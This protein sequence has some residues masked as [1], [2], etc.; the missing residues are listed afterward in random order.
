MKKQ[1][2]NAAS[3]AQEAVNRAIA[4]SD[5]AGWAIIR[6]R[7]LPY[8]TTAKI[9]QKAP[10]FVAVK[11]VSEREDDSVTLLYESDYTVEGLAAIVARREREEGR[12]A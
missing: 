1:R 10:R 11:R 3:R 5:A 9:E 7:G 6:H 8:L 2:R 12:K 4:A